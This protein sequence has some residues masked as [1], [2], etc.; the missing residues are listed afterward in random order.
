MTEDDRSQIPEDLSEEDLEAVAGGA[1]AQQ[2]LC[3]FCV[4]TPRP[5]TPN[6]AEPPA[7]D[8]P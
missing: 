2:S 1:E 3:S 6:P 5:E 8:A 7:P 4:A